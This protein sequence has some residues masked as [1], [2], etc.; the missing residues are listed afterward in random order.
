MSVIL[1]ALKKLDREK[2]IRRGGLP[3]IAVE[4]LRPDFLRPGKRILSYVAAV[5]LATA[6]ITYT[7]MVK[8][9][10][11]SKSSPPVPVNP[12]ASS[13]QV[14]PVPSESGVV[15]KSS[16]P[17]SINPPL[18]S[19]PVPSA[20]LSH[21]PVHAPPE[22]ISRVPPKIQSQEESKIPAA[23]STQTESVLGPRSLRISG[24]VWSEEP[25]NR[26]AVI[27]GASITEGSFIEGVRVVEIFP[28]HVRFL[29]NNR[30]FEIPLGSSA[31][32]P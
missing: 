15:V 16:P 22:A 32:P 4:I 10:S 19:Q 27:N 18:P 5:S 23:E 21:E 2:S 30:P 20:P 12:P 9:G 24:I 11:L 17:P 29:H 13:Q 31:I 25:L 14:L 8:F 28:T 7:V 1:D 6:V 3:N 26:I